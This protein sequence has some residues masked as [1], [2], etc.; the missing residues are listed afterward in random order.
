M[1]LAAAL[2]VSGCAAR[3]TVKSDADKKKADKAASGPADGAPSGPAT[4]VTEA[5]LKVGGEFSPHESLKPVPF[6]YDSAN[7][8]PDALAVLKANAEI[9]KADGAVEVL[10]A[11][12]CDERGTVAYNLALGQK[13]AKEVR[14]YYI[15]LGV[16][17][18]RV[19]TISYGKEQPQCSE[20]TD[21][22]WARNRRAE[23]LARVKQP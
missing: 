4:E 2:L 16:N 18:R 6:D 21:E 5:G 17:G 7:L 20:Q 12:H 3:K 15:R 13:R 23:S 1:T 8:S 19:A 14:D 22:C 11:G 10:V 9:L